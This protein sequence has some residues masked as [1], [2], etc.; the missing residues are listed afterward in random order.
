MANITR[1]D[2]EF[3]LALAAEISLRPHVDVYPFLDANK[4]LRDLK[5]KKIQGAKVLKIA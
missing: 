4:A 5:F 2:V 1:H 3:F